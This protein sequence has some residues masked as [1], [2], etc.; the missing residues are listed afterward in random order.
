MEKQH[1]LSYSF[2]YGRHSCSYEVKQVRGV[3]GLAP[4]DLEQ[5]ARPWGICWATLHRGPRCPEPDEPAYEMRSQRV[6]DHEHGGK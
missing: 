3:G 1:L 5:R 2:T 4:G 6:G